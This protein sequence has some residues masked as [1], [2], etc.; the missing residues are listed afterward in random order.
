MAY[1]TAN[2]S[3]STGNFLDNISFREFYRIET[4][5]TPNG[6]GT[7]FYNANTK[8]ADFTYAKNYVGKQE[9]NSYFMVDAKRDD[10]A[11]FIGAFVNGEFYSADDDAHWTRLE[12]GTYR[13]EADKVTKHYKVHLVFSKAGVQYDVNGGK[14][15]HTIRTMSPRAI[16]YSF[17]A[18]ERAIPPMLPLDKT[19]T[20]S[21]WAGSTRAREKPFASMPNTR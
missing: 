11:V 20:G 15:Y 12:D 8:T 6:S 14:A 18:L 10:G 4:Y 17:L 9:K 5:T 2:G 3:N 13:F 19:T 1:N 7:Y 21:L 16:S